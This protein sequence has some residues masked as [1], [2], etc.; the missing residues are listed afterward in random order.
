MDVLV[1][2]A[3]IAACLAAEAFFSGSEIGV[4]SADRLKLRAAAQQGSRGARLALSMLEKPEWLLSTTLVGTNIAVVTNTTVATALAI[5]LLGPSY[6]WVA[7][8]VVAP[9]IWIFGEIVA[10]SVF[11]QRADYLTPR[12]IYLLRGASY[13]FFPLLLVFSAISKVVARAVGGEQRQNPFTLREEIVSMVDMSATEGDILPVEKVMIRRVFDFGET[14]VR[15][16]MV[17]LIE[18]AGVELQATCGE[19]IEIAVEQGHKRY[20]VHD[21]RVDRVVG[22]INVLQLPRDDPNK[23]I[24]PLVQPIRFVPGAKSVE[25]LLLSFRKDGDKMAVIVD[26]FGG[27]EGI[28]TLEDILEEVVGDLQDEYDDTNQELRSVR[29]LGENELLVG[30]RV[31]LD[32]L[33][34]DTGIR[35]PEGNYETVGGF[36]LDLTRDIPKSGQVIR[37]HHITFT[38]E[39]A[40]AHSIEEVRIR[41]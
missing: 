40:T 5:R 29:R 39:K 19:A 34:E 12:A 21:E 28:V 24:K 3:I 1:S 22:L 35:L 23:P 6:G 25:D 36:L 31:E 38:I 13:L 17:P 41:V 26:E 14:T 4:V 11:Q 2:V 27:A 33:E 8:P 9:L 16:I 10:K 7:I 18:V 32:R 15:E 37:Y 20:P 30:A